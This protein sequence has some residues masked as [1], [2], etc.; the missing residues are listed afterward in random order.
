MKRVTASREK[1][2]QFPCICGE[3]RLGSAPRDHVRAHGSGAPKGVDGLGNEVSTAAQFAHAH[4]LHKVIL[5]YFRLL[6]IR[7]SFSKYM[8]K[9]VQDYFVVFIKFN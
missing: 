1:V 6:K 9:Q 4:S 7:F 3:W 2:G 5:L 8:S